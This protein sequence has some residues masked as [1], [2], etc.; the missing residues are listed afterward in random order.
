MLEAGATRVFLHGAGTD[1]GAV[2]V[3]GRV[4]GDAFSRQRARGPGRSIGLLHHR[5]AVDHREGLAYAGRIGNERRDVAVA[6]AADPDAA[7]PRPVRRVDRARLR[8][9]AVDDVVFVD[10]D[11][12]Q[13]AEL[14]P[15]VERLVGLGIENLDAVVR[16]VGHE[17]PSLRIERGTMRLHE[18]A[19][20]AGAQLS[21]FAEELA[22]LV[23]AHEAR[24]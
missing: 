7:H 15:R 3:A 17:E 18:L 24:G 13:P 1:L 12:A 19:L 8:I 22:G 11:A 14:V 10:R 9:S 2:D 6:R 23:E 21:K 5:L 16:T 20:G 4:H